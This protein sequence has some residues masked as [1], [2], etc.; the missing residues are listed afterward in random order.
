MRMMM[1]LA[2]VTAVVGCDE[3]KSAPETK[4]TTTV[5]PTPTPATT[6]V[7]PTASGEAAKPLGEAAKPSG[8]AVTPS[9]TTASGEAARAATTKAP[10]KGGTT[11][12]ALPPPGGMPHGNPEDGTLK[13]NPPPSQN[14][15]AKK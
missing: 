14:P 4:P 11:S 10:V 3:K 15:P 7:A 13:D 6:A 8:E 12:K 1:A 2:L 5:A 9:G